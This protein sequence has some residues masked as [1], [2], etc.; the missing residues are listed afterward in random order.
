M[1]GAGAFWSIKDD[2]SDHKMPCP[3]DTQNATGA[4]HRVFL[5]ETI[6]FWQSK[7]SIGCVNFFDQIDSFYPG[8]LVP[9]EL[10]KVQIFSVFFN[11]DDIDRRQVFLSAMTIVYTTDVLG[12]LWL[13]S[14]NFDP[15]TPILIA[16]KIIWLYSRYSI[17]WMTLKFLSF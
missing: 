13:D 3:L 9:P 17:S 4:R 10:S 7:S 5:I 12:I 14:K 8:I 16:L 15:K 1:V 2:I 11:M 6:N